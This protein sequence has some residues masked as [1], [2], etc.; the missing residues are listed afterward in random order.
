MGE[1]NLNV[2]LHIREGSYFHGAANGILTRLQICDHQHLAHVHGSGHADDAA[3]RE[4]NHGRGL[5]FEG[6]GARG[7]TVWRVAYS[8]AVN[9]DRNFER[10]R[11]GTQVAGSGGGWLR[12]RGGAG[13]GNFGRRSCDFD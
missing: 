12:L 9:F 13:C 11:V 5:F 8:R 1:F 2:A 6:L 3:V 10:E 4:N 7:S